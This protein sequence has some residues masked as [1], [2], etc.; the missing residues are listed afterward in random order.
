M[1]RNRRMSTKRNSTNCSLPSLPKTVA[2]ELTSAPT[3]HRTEI[4]IRATRTQ[5]V[6]GEN[7]RRIRELTGVVQKRFGFAD[8]A[9]ELYAERV[10][11]RR[12]CAQAQAGPLLTRHTVLDLRLHRLPCIGPR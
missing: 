10:Q 1:R 6:L 9:V 2:P 12:L 7:G 8:G 5:D 4:I 3:P 11:N